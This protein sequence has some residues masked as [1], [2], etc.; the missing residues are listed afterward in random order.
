[1]RQKAVVWNMDSKTTD[2][3]K[4][5][6]TGQAL[7]IRH[8]FPTT[9]DIPSRQE[10]VSSFYV[11]DAG[12]SSL[13]GMSTAKQ[14]GIFKLGPNINQIETVSSFP[15]IKDVILKLN[16]DPNFKPVQQPLR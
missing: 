13:L 7:Q 14:L 3:L 2:V 9:I 12:N 4:S 6:A 10:I 11:I 16:I 1:M 15:K 5:Y 8:R